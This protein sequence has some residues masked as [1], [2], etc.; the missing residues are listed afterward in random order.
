[1]K[2]RLVRE[3]PDEGNWLY[4]IKFDGIRAL[5]VKHKKNV[6][7]YSRL[8]NDLSGR[9]PE[10]VRAVQKLPCQQAVIDGEIVALDPEGRSS[11]QLLQS[12]HQPRQRPPIRYYV[13][14][15]V[16]LEGHDLKSL[17]LTRRKESLQP[18]IRERDSTIRFSANIMG[19]P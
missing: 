15:L 1:M 11:F 19:D 5:A 6:Q 7:L 12:A 4:E 8:N 17:P 16:N 9:F 3:M 14:D 18:L 2:A 10:V 13:F